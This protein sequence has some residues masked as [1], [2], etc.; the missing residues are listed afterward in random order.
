MIGI[1][2][3]AILPKHKYRKLEQETSLQWDFPHSVMCYNQTV[4]YK[5]ITLLYK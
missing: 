5:K 4:D 3:S 1:P 2:I